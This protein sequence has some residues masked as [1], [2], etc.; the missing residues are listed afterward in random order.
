[1][2]PRP[3]PSQAGFWQVLHKGEKR[4]SMT[5]NTTAF[6][7]FVQCTSRSGRREENPRKQAVFRVF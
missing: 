5:P 2:L 1:M 4:V 7:T 6:Y 3:A